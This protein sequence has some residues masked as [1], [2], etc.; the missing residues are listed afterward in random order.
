MNPRTLAT[1]VLTLALSACAGYS[2]RGMQ[3]GDSADDVLRTMGQPTSRYQLPQGG[4]RLEFARGPY[5]KHTYMIDVDAQGRVT[6]ATLLS[7]PGYGF[8]AAAL[9]CARQHRF[10]PATDVAGRPIAASSPPIR[11]RFWR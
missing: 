9:R 7:D 1:L 8:G 11:V 6:A 2:P 5:G 3:V 10:L 4:T